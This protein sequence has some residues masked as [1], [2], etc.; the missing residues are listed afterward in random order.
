MSFMCCSSI[1]GTA[2]DLCIT[3]IP[4]TKDPVYRFG[5]GLAVD[6]AV[7][8]LLLYSGVSRR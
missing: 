3:P 8:V 7:A 1:I 2:F 5:S 4:L 6:V